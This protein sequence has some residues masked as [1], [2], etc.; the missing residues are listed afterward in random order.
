MKFF[1]RIAEEVAESLIRLYELTIQVRDDDAHGGLVKGRTQTS[2]GCAQRILSQAP[3]AHIVKNHYG[4][5]ELAVRIANRRRAVLDRNHAAVLIDQ[6]RM[7]G[8]ANDSFG[9][10]HLADRIFDWLPRVFI[11]DLEYPFQRLAPG[12]CAI[13]TRH[14][15][16][17]RVQVGDPGVDVRCDDR[18]PD[19]GQRDFEPFALLLQLLGFMFQGLL[20]SEELAFGALARDADTFG[21]L[22]SSGTQPRFFLFVRV[23]QPMPRASAA[24]AVPATRARILA[25]AVS[26]VVDVSS[27]NGEN[28][29]SSV[30]PSCSTGMYSAAS[31][32]RSRTSSGVSTRGLIGATTPTNTRWCG[33]R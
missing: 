23:H 6:G 11:Y 7:V 13:P 28:P 18:I 32:T 31:R 27:Q 26:R 33:F 14:R 2:L 10:Q 20:G 17:D 5:G 30:V 12:L 15:F 9:L 21:I 25:N 22:K 24:S 8:E 1:A 3:I 19:T 29:Q 16:G 4:A